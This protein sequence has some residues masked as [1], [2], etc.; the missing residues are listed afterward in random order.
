MLRFLA[1]ALSALTLLALGFAAQTPSA[2]L[3]Q[4]RTVILLR[5]AEKDSAG[6]EDPA[7]S[8]R[9]QAR[10]QEIA[11]LLSASKA[12]QLFVTPYRRTQA[13]LQPLAERL[14]LSTSVIPAQDHDKLIETC[15]K[16][17][18]GSTTIICGHSNTIPKF[19]LA[20][21]A[22][23][24]GLDDKQRLPE[25]EFT[26]VFVLHLPPVAGQQATLVTEL[27]LSP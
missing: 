18:P 19:A 9:G 20:L 7:L 17:A 3:P 4:G 12:T 15:W 25:T 5:H 26:R 16:A 11:R 10:A 8:E 13:T 22:R 2:A 24:D 21:G 27:A 6:G 14:K 1:V 23:L